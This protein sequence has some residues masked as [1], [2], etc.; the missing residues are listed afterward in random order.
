[1]KNTPKGLLRGAKFNTHSVLT[2]ASVPVVRFLKAREDVTHVVIGPITR[3]RP[4]PVR[5]K[6]QRV[7]AGLKLSVRGSNSQQL[8][9][10]YTKQPDLTEN[11]LRKHWKSLHQ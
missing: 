10:A 5:L 7:V 4:A 11:D 6:V 3:I 2:E 1:M 9:Y 8:L